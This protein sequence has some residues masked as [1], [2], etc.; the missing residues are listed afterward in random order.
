MNRFIW[1]VILL[2]VLVACSAPT[3]VPTMTKPPVTIAPPATNTPVATATSAPPVP[4]NTVVPTAVPTTAPTATSAPSP[5]RTVVPTVLPTTAPTATSA[6]SPTRTVVPTVMQYTFTVN[7]EQFNEIAND[8]LSPS[9]VWYA[10]SASVTLQNGQVG[11]SANY[12]P[13][14]IKPSIAKVSLAASASNCNLRVSV[15]GA[16]F[17][18]SALPEPQKTALGQSI[19]RMLT[20]QVAQQ[21]NYTCIDS[22]TIANG[23]MTIKYH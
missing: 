5:T 11:I 8:A 3:P 10:D 16:T 7:E 17:G 2:I 15:V 20:Y 9:I 21:R 12:Y 23:L 13:P 18:Y 1:L 14:N 4:T 22:V 19:E 6:P